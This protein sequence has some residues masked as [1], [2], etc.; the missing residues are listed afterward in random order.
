MTAFLESFLNLKACV[1]YFLSNFCL[2][3]NDSPSKNVKKCF[4][5]HLKSSS[6]SR[7]IRVFCLP[8]FFSLSA[9]ALVVD[10]RKI[11][12]VYDAINCISKNLI[13]QFVWYLKKEIGCDILSIIRVSKKEHFME[14]SCRKCAPKAS[15]RSLFN[16]AI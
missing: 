16:F 11:L 2:S 15:P 4:L 6:R 10:P 5:F 1:R 13:T 3:P 14:K 9:T 12:K 8:L 7:D